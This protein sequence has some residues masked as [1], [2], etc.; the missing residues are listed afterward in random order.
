ML[1]RN[2][3]C[4]GGELLVLRPGGEAV[5]GLGVVDD[6]AEQFLAERGQRTL[7]QL[8]C[9]LALFDETPLLG[10][11][12]AGIHAVG[13]VVDGAAGDRIAFPDGPFRRRDAAVSWQQRGMVADTAELCSRQRL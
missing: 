13:E 10:G 7:P 6:F 3:R 11:D 2:R 12:G 5:M 1:L 8:P 4:L 9:R